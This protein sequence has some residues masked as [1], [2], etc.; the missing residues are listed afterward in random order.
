MAGADRR[1]RVVPKYAEITDAD[2]NEPEFLGYAGG[3]GDPLGET[4]EGVFERFAQIRAKPI[5]NP[6]QK[7][8][9]ALAVSRTHKL[10]LNKATK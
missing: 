4:R 2:L 7:A 9:G 8:S 6:W 5:E 10:Q 1:D 3:P